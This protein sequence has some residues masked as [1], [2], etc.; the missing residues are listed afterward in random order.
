M[1][2]EKL[3]PEN[4]Y[5]F[6]TLK[7]KKLQVKYLQQ[8][9]K[10]HASNTRINKRILPHALHHTCATQYHRQ[11]KNIKTLR[12]IL[13]HSDISTTTIYI[14]LVNTDL[15]NKESKGVRK[16]II[17][18]AKEKGANS[19][20]LINY[21]AKNCEGLIGFLKKKKYISQQTT[22]KFSI[23]VVNEVK[24]VFL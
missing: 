24:T 23:R 2:R 19:L 14:T 16:L 7:D 18:K 12:R 15:E 20:E 3:K 1:A 9:V 11:S 17:G 13:D 10:R 8:M 22:K 21:F 6:S 4:S 5:S